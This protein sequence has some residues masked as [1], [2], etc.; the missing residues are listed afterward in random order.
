MLVKDEIRLRREAATNALEAYEERVNRWTAECLNKKVVVPGDSDTPLNPYRQAGQS[1]GYRKFERLIDAL[2]PWLA[3][4]VHPGNAARGVVWR[5]R[6]DGRDYVTAYDR[7]ILPE[8]SIFRG[9]WV[10]EADP[11]YRWKTL[12]RADLRAPKPVTLQQAD[13]LIRSKGMQGALSELKKREADIDPDYR[14]GQ[15]KVLKLAGEAIRGWR[16]HLVKCVQMEACSLGDI[17]RLLPKFGLRAHLDNASWANWTGRKQAA[18][19]GF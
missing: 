18:S 2:S 19:V 1:I 3:T 6:S 15:R 12:D 10:W 5:L 9:Y 16:T 8:L 14:P 4:S 7:A 11:D 13:D 17:E